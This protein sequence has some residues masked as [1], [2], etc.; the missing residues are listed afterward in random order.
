MFINS[1]ILRWLTAYQTPLWPVHRSW[2]TH[3][4]QNPGSDKV[5]T[6]VSPCRIRQC[7]GHCSDLREGRGRETQ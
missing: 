6:L 2:E 5:L 4:E 1:M 7:A 3:Q